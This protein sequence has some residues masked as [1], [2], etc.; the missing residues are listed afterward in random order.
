MSEFVSDVPT[1]SVARNFRRQRQSRDVTSPGAKSINGLW[2]PGKSKHSHTKSL[3]RQDQCSKRLDRP[4][5]ERV[6]GV[7]GSITGIC[8][9]VKLEDRLESLLRGR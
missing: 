4:K 2:L 6:T 9:V 7:L 8:A 3:D 1:K 5:A